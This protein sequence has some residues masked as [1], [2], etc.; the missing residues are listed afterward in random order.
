MSVVSFRFA[1]AF[2]E[3]AKLKKDNFPG[4]EMRMTSAET[5]GTSGEELS[6]EGIIL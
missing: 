2:V 3:V 5:N 4:A 1:V 6:S